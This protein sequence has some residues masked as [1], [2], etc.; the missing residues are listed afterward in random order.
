MEVINGKI[1]YDLNDNIR[2]FKSGEWQGSSPSH[3]KLSKKMLKPEVLNHRNPFIHGKKHYELQ[4]LSSEFANRPTIKIFIKQPDFNFIDNTIPKITKGRINLHPIYSEPIFHDRKC[5]EN[6]III[7]P[8]I[9]YGMKHYNDRYHENTYE[10]NLENTLGAKKRFDDLLEIR[11]GFNNFSHG[12]KIYKN[13]EYSPNF[14]NMEGIIAGSTNK[15]NFNKSTS[16][17]TNNFYNTLDLSIKTLNPDKLWS[18]KLLKE[19]LDSDNKYLTN[20][21][22]WE[23]NYLAPYLPEANATQNNK[24]NKNVVDTSKTKTIVKK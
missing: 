14:Y 6:N 19:S 4:H 1:N 20:M 16:K 18:N 23:D 15:I 8:E 9:I 7:K 10:Y 22:K 17:R 3:W 13:V 5:L 11:N 2:L 21:V 24:N 12:D